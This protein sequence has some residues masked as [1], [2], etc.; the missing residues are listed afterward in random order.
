MPRNARHRLRAE[1][2]GQNIRVLPKGKLDIEAEDEPTK[3][4]GTVGVWA[5]AD[6]LTL[7]DRVS[8]GK[9]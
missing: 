6:S 4:A 7:F 8:R 5:K 2:S 3:E 1:C 9:K